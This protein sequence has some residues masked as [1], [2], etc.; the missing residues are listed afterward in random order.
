MVC[1]WQTCQV[2]SVAHMC[3]CQC[4]TVRRARRGT[5]GTVDCEQV[6]ELRF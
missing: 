5:A 4:F 3:L 6:L 1:L 2:S